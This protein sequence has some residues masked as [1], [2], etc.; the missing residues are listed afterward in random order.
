M[1]AGSNGSMLMRRRK[2]ICKFTFIFIVIVIAIAI[3]MVMEVVRLS[4]GVSVTWIASN[5]RLLH[6]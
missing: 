4:R 3:A 1:R 6:R 2:R 5:I